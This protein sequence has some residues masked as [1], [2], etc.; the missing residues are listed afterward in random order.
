MAAIEMCRGGVEEYAVEDEF[1]EGGVTDEVSSLDIGM[2][3]EELYEENCV[4]REELEK[5]QG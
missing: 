5:G 4:S 1:G 3:E 2:E